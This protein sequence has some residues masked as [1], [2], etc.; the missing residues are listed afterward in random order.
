MMNQSISILGAICIFFAFGCSSPAEKA[1]PEQLNSNQLREELLQAN[2]QVIDKENEQ[3]DDLVRR[4][5]W[6]MT[7]TGTGLRYLIYQKGTGPLAKTGQWVK[8]NYEVRLITGDVIYSSK[9]SGP[10]EFRIG[11]GGVESGL[12]EAILKLSVG[13]KAKLILPSHL[14]HGL[15]GDQDKIPPKASLI[16]DVEVLSLDITQN[17]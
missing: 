1:Q 8:L 3:I 6:K 16:Y 15:A 13:D 2:K 12:E 11:S 10:K 9:Q 5:G 17:H 7:E 4:Y 14:A